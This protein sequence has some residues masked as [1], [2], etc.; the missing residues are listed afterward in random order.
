MA[1]LCELAVGPRGR[2]AQHQRSIRRH[3]RVGEAGPTEPASSTEEWERHGQKTQPP[4]TKTGRGSA[5]R[6]SP[7]HQRLREAGR[8]HRT[9]STKD[10]ERQGAPWPWALPGPGLPSALDLGSPWVLALGFPGPRNG[11]TGP[12]WPKKLDWDWAGS[13]FNCPNA[14]QEWAAV[15][16]IK[17][18]IHLTG[19]T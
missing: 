1:S 2:H 13:P 15:H 7:E 12:K 5:E 17:W 16:I 8:R 11:P 9:T 4:A 6:A 14:W 18:H 10:W 19:P 3:Q